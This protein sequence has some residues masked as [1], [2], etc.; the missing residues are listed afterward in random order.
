MGVNIPQLS[1]TS[2]DDI[3]HRI[4]TLRKTFL[5]HKTRDV[6]FRLVQLRKLYWA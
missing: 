4:S 3:T 5:Q 6:Q 2:H 1:F